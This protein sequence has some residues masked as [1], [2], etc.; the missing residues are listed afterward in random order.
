MV[1]SQADTERADLDLE[2]SALEE[3]RDTEQAE[4]REIYVRRGLDRALAE[5]VAHQLMVFD[6]LGAHARDE[7][8]ITDALS[9]RPLQASA[10]SAA[11]FLLGGLVPLAACMLAPAHRVIPVIALVS[12]MFLAALGAGAARAG[13]APLWRGAAR[14]LA[15]GA[16]VMGVT[17]AVGAW[18]LSS[19]KAAVMI[20]HGS[21]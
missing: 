19:P 13:G 17:G 15:W 10:A 20:T 2:R 9:A 3:D 8:G 11:S 14:V 4:L 7:I 1:S 6:A 16:L 18:R 21:K 12:M 5:Q